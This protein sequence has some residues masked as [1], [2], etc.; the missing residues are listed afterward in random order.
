MPT[1]IEVLQ[2]AREQGN[3][4][5][6]KQFIAGVQ[7]LVFVSLL[8]LLGSK[9]LAGILNG[10]LYRALKDAR[11]AVRTLES[12]AVSAPIWATIIEIGEVTRGQIRAAWEAEADRLRNRMDWEGER[13]CRRLAVSL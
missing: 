5:S 8:R 4:A 13:R 3:F 6:G 1:P 12:P 10:D 2:K 9:W 7:F 11:K